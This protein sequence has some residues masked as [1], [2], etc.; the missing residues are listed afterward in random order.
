MSKPDSPP[1]D[2]SPTIPV[3]RSHSLQ[4]KK[5]RKVERRERWVVMSGGVFRLCQ[6]WKDPASG[7][8]WSL[9]TPPALHDSEHLSNAVASSSSPTSTT[10]P[11]T[12]D[13][14]VKLKLSI[15]CAKSTR[16]H[17]V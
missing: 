6:D 13:D 17:L 4:I 12:P 16:G 11:S 8:P 14:S 7:Q 5:C 10:L 1:S 3:R 15:I 9:S 2:P